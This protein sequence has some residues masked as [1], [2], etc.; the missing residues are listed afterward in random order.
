MPTWETAADWDN[1]T[2]ETGT[3]H[4]T[5]SDTDYNDATTLNHAIPVG[6][7]DANITSGLIAHHPLQE[8]SGGTA[9][10]FAGNNDGTVNGA[11][12]GATGLLGTSAYKFDG[13]DEV[14]A[15]DLD[16]SGD[17]TVALW[18]F[19]KGTGVL[20]GDAGTGSGWFVSIDVGNEFATGVPK[21]GFNDGLG[22]VGANTDRRGEWIHLAALLRNGTEEI[23]V[24]GSQKGTQSNRSWVD[25]G[26]YAIGS[27]NGGNFFEGRIA[28]VRVYNRALSQS[29]I[30]QLHDN[31]RGTASLTTATKSL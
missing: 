19:V 10:D 6:S 8:D 12:Q 17:N 28:S 14:I 31:V 1:A 5:L 20:V 18:V 27:F 22:N 26:K 21:F 13:A 7:T 25:A 30:A 15:A 24:N 23:Y 3:M 16:L 2:S 4:D 29:E 9:V 11:T